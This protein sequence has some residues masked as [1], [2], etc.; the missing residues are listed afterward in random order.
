LRPVLELLE[1]MEE[2]ILQLGSPSEEKA[3]VLREKARIAVPADG[4]Q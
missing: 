2:Y 4:R 3:R 1:Y